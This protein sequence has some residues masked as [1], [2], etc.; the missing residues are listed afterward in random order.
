MQKLVIIVVAITVG[1]LGSDYIIS[2]NNLAQG[3]ESRPASR[4]QQL[5]QGSEQLIDEDSIATLQA[6]TLRDAE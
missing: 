2:K 6:A 1:I 3:P 4:A 5:D